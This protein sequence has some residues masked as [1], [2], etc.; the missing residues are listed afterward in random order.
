MCMYIYIF[1]RE[2]KK[3]VRD[4]ERE[5]RR[6]EAVR[7]QER[8]HAAFYFL[9]LFCSEL[10]LFNSQ[11]LGQNPRLKTASIIYKNIV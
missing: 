8:K 10:F 9:L 5:T 2:R 4:S 1:F 6:G 11:F 7:K 3:H